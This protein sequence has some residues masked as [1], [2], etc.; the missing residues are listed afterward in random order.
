MAGHKN[1]KSYPAGGTG[2]SPEAGS[3][4]QLPL[5]LTAILCL[6]ALQD[7][8]SRTA[9]LD[10]LNQLEISPA[11]HRR[12]KPDEM[13]EALKVLAARGWL[14]AAD[15]R[16]R[17]TPGRENAVYL[18]MVTHPSAWGGDRSRPG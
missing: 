8:L 18:Y 17:L 5:H 11:A 16:W 12:M 6:L 2:I 14:Q 15:N 4:T 1:S 13:A 3:L 9:L 10:G 7:D